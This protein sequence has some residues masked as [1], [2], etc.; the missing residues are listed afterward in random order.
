MKQN[1]YIRALLAF[2]L[3]FTSTRELFFSILSHTTHTI[4]QRRHIVTGTGEYIILIKRQQL[5]SENS[6]ASGA[7]NKVYERSP[8]IP[9]NTHDKITHDDGR[10]SILSHNEKY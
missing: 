9:E 2:F 6:S 3:F 7:V 4:V 5:S 10:D 8:Y 1:F